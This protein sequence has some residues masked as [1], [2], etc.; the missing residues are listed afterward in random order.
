MR[1]VANARNQAPKPA[2]AKGFGLLSEAKARLMHNAIVIVNAARRNATTR[3]LTS[4][5]LVVF[6]LHRITFG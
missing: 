6:P 5:S 3:G 1:N 2:A 4:A